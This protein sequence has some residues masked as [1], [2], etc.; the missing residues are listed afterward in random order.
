M[1][2]KEYGGKLS[3]PNQC[4]CLEELGISTIVSGTEL[5]L[6]INLK[7]FLQSQDLPVWCG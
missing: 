7:R 1:A 5:L 2:L 4:I 3:W 6:Y